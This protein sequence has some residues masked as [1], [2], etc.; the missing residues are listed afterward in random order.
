MKG[1][2]KTKE[3]LHGR[4]L[5]VIRPRLDRLARN[6]IHQAVCRRPRPSSAPLAMRHA[7]NGWVDHCN[8]LNYCWVWASLP[9]SLIRAWAN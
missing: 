8:S 2:G 9:A 4:S 3:R 1:M 5:S 6:V 7:R